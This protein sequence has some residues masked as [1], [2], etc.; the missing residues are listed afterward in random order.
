MLNESRNIL[1]GVIDERRYNAELEQEY[2]QDYEDP[3]PGTILIFT[4][5]ENRFE[6]EEN[7]HRER[8][9]TWFMKGSKM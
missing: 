4:T 1:R 8:V 3:Y 2:I 9:K 7:H 5:K 6:R